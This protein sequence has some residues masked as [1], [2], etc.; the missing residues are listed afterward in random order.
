MLKYINFADGTVWQIWTRWRKEGEGRNYWV[1]DTNGEEEGDPREE[2]IGGSGEG[3]EGR[4]ERVSEWVWR[5]W[6]LSAFGGVLSPSITPG[7]P[8]PPAQQEGSHRNLSSY[9]DPCDLASP[10]KSGGVDGQKTKIERENN[11]EKE[12]GNIWKKV[13]GCNL[14]I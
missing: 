12:K 8:H 3:N 2:G 1:R 6:L 11:Q 4:G 5:G 10:V 14:L 9:F 7:R 13:K